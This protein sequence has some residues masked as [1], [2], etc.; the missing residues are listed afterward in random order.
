MWSDA[1]S[2]KEL[3]KGHLS[4]FGI[5][6]GFLCFAITGRYSFPPPHFNLPRYENQ[7]QCF[8]MAARS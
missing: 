1:K 7:F 5:T 8:I 2:F 3:R 4:L 6:V